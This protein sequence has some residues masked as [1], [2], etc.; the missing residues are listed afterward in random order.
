MLPDLQLKLIA[1]IPD[2]VD[3]VRQLARRVHVPVFESEAQSAG[4]ETH[5]PI[6][7]FLRP[8]D[9]AA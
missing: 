7:F 6:R 4:S 9:F 5:V 2:E 1:I 3:L 8:P